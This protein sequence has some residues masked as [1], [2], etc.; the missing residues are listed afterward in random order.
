M[1]ALTPLP[2]IVA[3]RQEI[4]QVKTGAPEEGAFD[5]VF[6]I[7]SYLGSFFSPQ[8]PKQLYD[9]VTHLTTTADVD[10]FVKY[11]GNM[12]AE[13]IEASALTPDRVEV[14]ADCMRRLGVMGIME[15]HAKAWIEKHA[16]YD[17]AAVDLTFNQVQVLRKK[18][19]AAV[20]NVFAYT[21]PDAP[22]LDPSSNISKVSPGISNGGNN[23]YLISLLQGLIGDPITRRWIIDAEFV[24]DSPLLD[25]SGK[26]IRNFVKV[27]KKCTFEFE[28]AQRLGRK[29]EAMKRVIN[30]FV[31]A[32]IWNYFV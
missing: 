28:E 8:D 14:R 5:W 24:H 4:A 6:D 9:K 32:S 1:E 25:N 22:P 12:Q 23:C 13:L 26:K 31:F 3:K 10:T 15:D 16:Q 7:F 30:H 20:P 2:Q 27:L 21:V 29:D 18:V 17:F 11:V 19:M